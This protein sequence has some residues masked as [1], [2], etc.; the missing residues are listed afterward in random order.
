MLG[1][2]VDILDLKILSKFERWKMEVPK[3]VPN[4]QN[5]LQ[6]VRRAKELLMDFF[7]KEES[8]PRFDPSSTN[9]TDNYVSKKIFGHNQSKS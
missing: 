2:N 5:K 7:L 8:N 1:P 3:F 4:F 9:F 6:N